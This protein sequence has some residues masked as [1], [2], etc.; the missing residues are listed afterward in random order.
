HLR[1]S[2]PYR[3]VFSE[4]LERRTLVRLMDALATLL[5]ELHL[6]GFI[7]GDVSLSNVLFR[8]DAGGFAAHLVDAETGELRE[9]LSNGQREH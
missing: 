4:R 5:V 3:A 1:F 6:E 9:R 8:R 7:W 2:L